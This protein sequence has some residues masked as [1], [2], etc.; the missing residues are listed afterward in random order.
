MFSIYSNSAQD[1]VKFQAQG[2]QLK[3]ALIQVTDM[4]GILHFSNSSMS[5]A[6]AIDVS[7]WMDGVYFITLTDEDGKLYGTVGGA[8]LA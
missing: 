4:F 1:V 3:V 8:T 6:V 7:N 5:R 2:S